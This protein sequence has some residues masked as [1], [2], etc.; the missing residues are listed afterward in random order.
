MILRTYREAISDAF[1]GG[2]PLTNL[3]EKDYTLN[4]DVTKKLD[5]PET[6]KTAIKLEETAKKFCEDAAA[7][8][9]GLMADVPQA[10]EWVAKRKIRRIDKIK[11]TS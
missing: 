4:I 3:D 9:K 6:L 1:E 8:T 7:S 11:S 2:F 5:L 10:F